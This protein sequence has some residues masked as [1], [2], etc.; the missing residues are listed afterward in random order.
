MKKEDLKLCDV[1]ELKNGE[2]EIML[3]GIFEDNIV[4]FMNI[5]DG[6]YVPFGEYNDD[7]THGYNSSWN[8][9][10]VKHF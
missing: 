3:H 2:V 6:R 8:I 7:L 10:K 1:V 9:M 4:V 5:K